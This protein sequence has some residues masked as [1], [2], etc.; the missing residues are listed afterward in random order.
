MVG[1]GLGRAG[2][3]W[4]AGICVPLSEGGGSTFRETPP[5]GG[6]IA[7]FWPQGGSIARFP[8]RSA[9]KR[10]RRRSFRKF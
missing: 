8:A 7:R 9:G 3:G 6:S 4:V 2:A 1:F 10:C 5:G